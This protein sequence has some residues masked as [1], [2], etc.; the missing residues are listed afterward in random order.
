[1]RIKLFTI[2]TVVVVV[3]SSC[4]KESNLDPVLSLDKKTSNFDATLDCSS[5]TYYGDAYNTNPS[6]EYGVAG[7]APDLFNDVYYSRGWHDGRYEA[8]LHYKRIGNYLGSQY[9]PQPNYE[10][11][12]HF[13]DNTN[14][15]DIEYSFNDRW[16]SSF[17]ATNKDYLGV[18]MKIPFSVSKPSHLEIKAALDLDSDVICRIENLVFYDNYTLKST[19][20]GAYDAGKLAGFKNA[21]KFEPLAP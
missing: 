20:R 11:R 16:S 2:F 8:L 21:I 10:M 3:L 1:M 6:A 9:I 15:V 7:E 19:E 12:F 14:N 13:H 18:S 5:I 4:T 17:D